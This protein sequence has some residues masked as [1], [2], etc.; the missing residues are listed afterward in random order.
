MDMLF[1]YFFS[2]G[3]SSTLIQTNKQTNKQKQATLII[4]LVTP[5]PGPCYT[6]QRQPHSSPAQACFKQAKPRNIYETKGVGKWTCFLFLSFRLKLQKRLGASGRQQSILYV[7]QSTPAS[8]RAVVAKQWLVDKTSTEHRRR[9]LPF[10]LG[11]R[12][13]KNCRRS[14][15]FTTI[16]VLARK[17]SSKLYFSHLIC[18]IVYLRYRLK[19]SPLAI[20]EPWYKQTNKQSLKSTNTFKASTLLVL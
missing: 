6:E 16:V 5:K 2:V 3:K 4:L 1:L 9:L 11:L 18:R 7:V 14:Y 19:S 13:L 17:P 15:L 20:H 8:Q 10:L 12:C